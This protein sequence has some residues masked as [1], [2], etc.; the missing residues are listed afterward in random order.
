MWL[1]EAK[2]FYRVVILIYIIVVDDFN[3]SEYKGKLLDT[4]NFL[5]TH[6]LLQDTNILIEF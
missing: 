3:I 2:L 1:L 5:S 4:Q 6:G